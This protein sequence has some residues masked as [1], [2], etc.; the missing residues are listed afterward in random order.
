MK[1]R[2]LFIQ[3][4]RS[5]PLLLI[6]L[7]FNGGALRAQN[8]PQY[9]TGDQ[10]KVTSDIETHLWFFP[11]GTRISVAQEGTGNISHIISRDHNGESWQYSGS[12]SVMI[13]IERTDDD[14]KPLSVLVVEYGDQTPLPAQQI[15]VKWDNNETQ[16]FSNN[17]EERTVYLRLKEPITSKKIELTFQP[18]S[19][20]FD[21]KKIYSLPSIQH[22]AAKWHKM[23][24]KTTTYGD[25]FDKT[26]FFELTGDDY[27][28]RQVQ[29]T[30]VMTDTIYMRRGTR[31]NLTLPNKLDDNQLT[32]NSMNSYIRW[33]SYRT[34]TT[35]LTEH[36]T[37]NG[38]F[39]NVG[40]YDLLTPANS[41][42]GASDAITRFDN[43]Y[44]L[45]PFTT[46]SLFAGM[47]FYFPTDDEFKAWFPSFENSS[48]I[49]NNLYVVACDVS[50]YADYGTDETITG[51][52]LAEKFKNSDYCEPTLTHRLIYYIKAVEEEE[53]PYEEYTINMPAT[54]VRS[55]TT[56]LVTLSKMARNY[57]SQNGTEEAAT[58]VATIDANDNSAGI[59]LCNQHDYDGGKQDQLI[60]TGT[61]R[62][63]TF[64]Y[65]RVNDD[66]TRTVIPETDNG[67]PLTA[68]IVVRH[69]NSDKVVAKF[70]LNFV[71]GGRLLTQSMVKLLDGE[72]V[73]G[74][75][76]D[77]YNTTQWATLGYRTPKKIDEDPNN[78]VLTELTMDYD[79]SEDIES[80]NHIKGYY[81]YPLAWNSSSYGFYD[82]TKKNSG[83]NGNKNC[84][85]W[86][87]YAITTKYVECGGEGEWE[88][89]NITRPN[90]TGAYEP[91]GYHLYIDASDRPGTIFRAPFRKKL[92][93]NAQLTFSAWVKVAREGIADNA[94]MLL[95]IMGK[96]VDEKGYDKY[97]PVYRYLTGQ[98]PAT[99]VASANLPGFSTEPKS[100]EWFHVYFTFMNGNIDYE[101]YYLQVDNYSASTAGADMYLDDVR[102]YMAKPKALVKQKKITCNEFTL[103]TLALDWETLLA[104]INAS[105][106]ETDETITASIDFCFVD[107]L[108]YAKAIYVDHLPTAEAIQASWM[109]IT[110]DKTRH[111]GHLS[112]NLNFSKNDEYPESEDKSVFS[113]HSNQFYRTGT[114]EDGNRQL[115]GD[116]NSAL[117]Q[118]RRYMILIRENQ[119]NRDDENVD[120]FTDAYDDCS[121]SASFSVESQNQV[122]ING[123]VLKP[124]KEQE[125]CVGQTIELAMQ[126]RVEDKDE[127]G[128]TIYKPYE[129]STVYYDWYFN[130]PREGT[131][132]DFET[133][134]SEYDNVT[135]KEALVLLREH[136]PNVTAEAYTDTDG[137][138]KYRL[139]SDVTA[140]DDFTNNHIDLINAKLNEPGRDAAVNR[141]LILRRER[142]TVRLLDND[143]RSL[144]IIP[145]PIT[146]NEKALIC[147]EPVD[148]RMTPFGS[149]PSVQPGFEYMNYPEETYNP[150]MRIGLKHIENSTQT[151]QITVNLRN[152]KYAR[153]LDEYG[154]NK[155]THVG[156]M[157]SG[158]D[159]SDVL[160][161]IYLIGSTDPA[162]KDLFTES[163][164]PYTYVIGK[165]H[166]FYA[167]PRKLGDEINGTNV[168]KIHFKD[169]EQMTEGD[170]DLKFDPKEGYEYTFMVRYEEHYNTGTRADDNENSDDDKLPVPCYGN[171]IMTMK[172]VPEYLV[173]QGTTTGL[174]WNDDSQ[175]KRA[176]NEDIHAN[177]II[178]NYGNNYNDN[179]GYVPMRFS[180]IIIPRDGKVELYKA[181]FEGDKTKYR[182]VE[183]KTEIN[184]DAHKHMDPPATDEYRKHPIQYDMM[185]YGKKG[186]DGNYTD[187]HTDPYTVNR[188]EEVHFE[189]G[190]EMMHAELL[191]Y[192]NQLSSDD[193]TYQKAW[194]EY[195]LE[196]GRWYALSSPLQ[197][198][199]SGDFYTGKDGKEAS[200]YFTPIQW[201]NNNSRLNPT[202]YQR[203][204][205]GS[206]ATM[207]GTG[208]DATGERAIAGNWS[209]LYNKV[210]ENYGE[211]GFSLRVQDIEG[212]GSKALFRLPKADVSYTYNSNDG[213]TSSGTISRE[214]SHKL[215][216]DNLNDNNNGMTVPLAANDNNPYYLVGN[217]FMAQLKMEEF[218]NKNTSLAKTYWL[219]DENN[220]QIAAN[221]NND[222]W[223]A[224]G[225]DGNNGTVPPLTSFFVK[226]ADNATTVPNEVTFTADMQTLDTEATTASEP[227]TPALYL[228]ITTADGR[229]SHA[230]IAYD[231]ASDKGYRTDEDA[232]LFLDSNLGNV[233]MVYTVAGTMAA[234][235]NR[236][237][238]LYD[239][240]VG[241]YGGDKASN[242]VL[243]F[244]GMESFA[245]V[246]LYDAVR[247]IETPLHE[248]KKIEIPAA[249]AGRYFL[250]AGMPTANETIARNA[251]RIYTVGR[252][253][254]IVTAA[255]APLKTI[256][257]HTVSG[258]QVRSIQADGMQWQFRL[259]TGLYLVTAIDKEGL[260]ETE[261]IVVK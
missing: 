72:E 76:L 79:E 18:N 73:N 9:A 249:T 51:T 58:L 179:P 150:A 230:S 207:V 8:N 26:E 114:K 12:E 84:A 36:R 120:G 90:T 28:N 125:Y 98:I 172:V 56:E 232:E 35:Y 251:F 144:K 158:M 46:K 1:H 178:P 99:Y 149:A 237:S 62:N 105:E 175:W 189:P 100:N 92:C 5:I 141:R 221:G 104:R 71:R 123:E 142:L 235:V 117:Q 140:K 23:R 11:D 174:N 200:E 86:G 59:E 170:K 130:S 7:L 243:S 31:V 153:E 228:T 82:G 247:K 75:T 203:G 258:K 127:N 52:Q 14:T 89:S 205:K 194:V 54:R 19:T 252:E 74:Q 110:T 50:Q 162:Y 201:N 215:R 185:V 245:S 151:N 209:A 143:G 85:E 93:S 154:A 24:S 20:Q 191:S 102:V 2:N 227:N 68:T 197:N 255:N 41:N 47:N 236:T 131:E 107:S 126:L 244:D 219:V 180:K 133:Q 115:I 53:P 57:L 119:G 40:V 55:Y 121:I 22:K 225:K 78:E 132:E 250:R 15:T 94:G 229:Q 257:V 259:P 208:T 136:Y 157:S 202:V 10:M 163:N 101:D 112:F 129:G 147:A 223:T 171:F 64:R 87:N 248:G 61:D 183:W 39:P 70:H 60:L 217:P 224:N 160:N 246:S 66:Q 49:D 176:T 169:G 193:I 81:P 184:D 16:I 103:M 37:Q 155:P 91:K 152:I 238:D 177:N 124:E 45:L 156:L 65:P 181:G 212:T 159:E 195:E 135:V 204:W 233:P 128:N 32:Q 113:E 188:C 108:D 146:E 109:P 240:P 106:E 164:S 198:V 69:Q 88:K 42:E 210:D 13:T 213:N 218:F 137:T 111:V 186:D 44:L 239:I 77:R 80:D 134:Q 27:V 145:I 83:F 226:K 165:V 34:G 97:V 48:K 254:V 122:L 25:T 206:S 253:Q 167:Q 148:L 33:Y 38:T 241:V 173:W 220:Q 95:T 261:K 168:M 3:F 231:A 192:K 222:A 242:V 21:I 139:P 116:F 6:L 187:M 138:T 256:L 234:S 211:N 96:T 17:I 67:Q 196:K 260:Q 166:S 63:I 216:I 4:L 199:F 30:H 161:D 118:N 190:A 182:N 29:A 43:G 214:N